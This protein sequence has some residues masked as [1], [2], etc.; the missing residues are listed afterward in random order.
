MT[1]KQ[2]LRKLRNV[3]FKFI[4]VRENVK[5]IEL[6]GKTQTGDSKVLQWIPKELIELAESYNERG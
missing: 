5:Y 6:L 3:G 4:K 1:E 2:A